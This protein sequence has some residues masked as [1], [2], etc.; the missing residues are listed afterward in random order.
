MVVIA[1]EGVS[2]RLGGKAVVSDVSATLTHGLIGVLGPNGAGKSTLVRAA[3]GLVPA[4]GRIAVEG[5]LARTLAYLPQGG[6]IHW[7]VSVRRLVGLGRL[8]HM[9]P[10]GRLGPADAAAVER[11]MAAAD[12]AH[13]ADRD[14]TA[15]SGGERARVLLARALATEA[16]ALVVDEPLAALDP[17]HALGVMALL[18]AQADGGTLV[19]AVLHDLGLAARFCDRVLLMQGG[20]WSRTARRAR[21]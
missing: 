8:A 4:E 2:V 19:V 9:G 20:G 11:A 13:L 14:A 1:L 18:R 7:P 21:C 16:P 17:R 12:V 5:P 10:L 3:L 15:L 6:A